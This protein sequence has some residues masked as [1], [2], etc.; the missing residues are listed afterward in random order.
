MDTLNIN[1]T[2]PQLGR[3]SGG[4][5]NKALPSIMP[6]KSSAP[7]LPVIGTPGESDFSDARIEEKRM[8]AV[9]VAAKDLFV[10]GDMRF[11]IFKDSTGQYITR[12]TSLRDGRVTYIPEPQ[13]LNMSKGASSAPVVTLNA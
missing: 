9:K 6:A 10:L 13:L 4:T 12:F 7:D 3:S 5:S 2:L 11:T 1:L 8:E